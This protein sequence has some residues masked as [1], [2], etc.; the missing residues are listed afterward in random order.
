MRK[1]L[2]IRFG[3][4]GDV[5]LAS[6]PVL[7]L[8][9]HHPN[10]HIAFLTKDRYRAVVERFD[11][12]DQVYT[13]NPEAGPL[14]LISLSKE[15]DQQDFDLVVDLHGN[16]RSWVVRKLTTAAQT[17]S[18]PK[19]RLE[20]LLAV[21]KHNKQ[22]PSVWPHT[23]DM[24]NQCLIDVG[25]A[26]HAARPLLI[27]DPGMIAPAELSSLDGS[28]DP[29]IAIAPGA[30]HPTKQWPLGR[31][32]E[33]AK[34]LYQDRGIQPLWVVTEEDA[35]AINHKWSGAPE[36]ANQLVNHPADR[37][38]AVLAKC[39]LTLA[40][41]SGIAH[42][43][44][45]VGTPVLAIF[46]PTHP[47][48]GFRPAGLFDQVIEVDEFCRPCSLHGKKP[49]YRE[50]QYCFTRITPELVADRVLNQLDKRHNRYPA[51]LVDRD[52][53]VIVDK[54]Y[55]SDPDQVEFEPGSIEALQ[56]ADQLGFKLVMLSN[57]SGVAR[58]Y[59]DVDSVERIHAYIVGRLARSGVQLD[60]IYYCPHHAHGSVP[61]FTRRCRCRKPAP[62]MAEDAAHQLGIDLRRSWVIG[63]KITD[64]ALGRII[65]ARAILVRTG[66][67]TTE[68]PLLDKDRFD[69]RIKT[70]D[71]LQAAV[72]LIKE[73]H[74][75]N[76]TSRIW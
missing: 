25:I 67:G 38:A 33:T 65:G 6:A 44:S 12:V 63:D 16:F 35:A 52:G 53:T 62:G 58:G 59:F 69:N 66:F 36:V 70:A 30:A 50:E 71:S 61:E 7:N 18:Y 21:R 3:S 17:V 14:Q 54:D 48:L 64:V 9:I 34:I 51:L 56:L 22:F 68:E 72:Q 57:Q 40:N 49:C 27:P 23:I 43:S 32:V 46:G 76:K 74:A 1:I 13:L 15:L 8:R 45:A 42:L 11:G 2:I 31:F 20:R 26:P 47:V 75:A 73:E 28:D 29:R 4:L 19:R 5:I 24:Y 39:D 10:C 55:L 41:D 37:L 60:G